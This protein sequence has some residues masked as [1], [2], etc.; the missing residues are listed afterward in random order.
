[1]NIYFPLNCKFVTN[2]IT[3][4]VKCNTLVHIRK[5][6][7]GGN[8]GLE[9]EWEGNGGGE[10]GIRA[11]FK[12]FKRFDRSF[13]WFLSFTFMYVYKLKGSCCKSKYDK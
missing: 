13:I 8:R 1:M 5:K 9:G 12:G 6:G 3:E 2:Q 4:T 10:G 7:E 11:G